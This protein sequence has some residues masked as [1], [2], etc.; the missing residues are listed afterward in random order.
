MASSSQLSLQLR[1]TMPLNARQ[2]PPMLATTDHLRALS[3]F[4]APVLQTFAQSS[5]K[6]QCVLA[7]SILG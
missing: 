2:F 6:V 3:L 7:N 4:S 5:Q 1:Q